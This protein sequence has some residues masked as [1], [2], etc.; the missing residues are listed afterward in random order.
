[1]S[2]FGRPL[3]SL[4]AES[5]RTWADK[6]GISVVVASEEDAGRLG[7]LEAGADFSP[8]RAIGPFRIYV[9]RAPRILPQRTGLQSWRLASPSGAGWRAAGFAYSPLWSAESGGRSLPT[10][11]DAAGM[12]E[13]DGPGGA[14]DITLHHIPGVAERIGTL[15][16]ALSAA[17]LA[18]AAVRRRGRGDVA[19][20]AHH[21]APPHPRR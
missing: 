8:P 19:V 10:R 20:T 5:F 14:S 6:L 21:S 18:V 12:L 11:R 7:F 13:I 3:E 9:A 1:V 17:A 15:V 16:S 4:T 2:L